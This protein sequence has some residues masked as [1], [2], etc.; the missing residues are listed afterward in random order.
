MIHYPHPIGTDTSPF[1][2]LCA[3]NAFPPMWQGQLG[4]RLPQ[5]VNHLRRWPPQGRL[6]GRR[7]KPS[8]RRFIHLPLPNKPLPS[9]L[10]DSP[11][12]CHHK[13]TTLIFLCIFS[14]AS[15][16]ISSNYPKTPSLSDVPIIMNLLRLPFHTLYQRFWFYRIYNAII[17]IH[18]VIFTS[19]VSNLR[20]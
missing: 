3:T 15:L 7:L 13:C 4:C 17:T 2:F 14:T 16:V 5:R 12:P 9:K 1:F 10:S 20:P 19:R 8:R 6:R 11:N 18:A